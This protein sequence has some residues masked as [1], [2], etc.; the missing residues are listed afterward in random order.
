MKK[1]KKLLIAIVIIFMVLLNN[2]AFA[3]SIN[4]AIGKTEYSQEFLDWL[5]LDDETKKNSIMPR[6]YN[7]YTTKQSYTNP[8]KRARL[9]RSTLETQYNLKNYIKDNMKIKNQG[10]MGSCWTFSAL[11]AL[12]TN[13][14]MQDLNNSR[15]TKIYDFSERHMDFSTA[16]EFLNGQI[17]EKGFNRT[18][19]SG[20]HNS[21]ALAYLTNG[22]GAIPESEMPY[23]DD[24]SL[25]DISEIQN[26]TVSSQLYDTIDFATPSIETKEDLVTAM[27]NHIRTYGGISCT[28]HE[29]DILE[30]KCL[31]SK[32]GAIY[33]NDYNT[34]IAN[35]AVLIVGWDDN[36]PIEN[37][38]T[39][40][41]NKGAWIIRDTHGTNEDNSMT[42]DELKNL[43]FETF[44]DD[45]IEEGIN[46][47]D[48]ITDEK[49]EEIIKKNGFEKLEDG[50]VFRP[51]NDDGYLYVSYEDDNIYNFLMGI[52]KANDS[53]DYENIYQYDEFSSFIPI[54]F[55][56]N[57]IYLSNTFKKQTDS[58]EY[59]TQVSVQTGETATCKVYVNPNGTGKNKEDL[60]L[61]ELKS[62]DSETVEA[63]YHTL[64]FLKPIEITGSDFV[65]VIEMQGKR[66]KEMQVPVECDVAKFLKDSEGID[67]PEGAVANFFS[68][69]TTEDGKCCFSTDEGLDSGYW[70]NLSDLYKLSRGTQPN[71]DSTIKAFTVS[72]VEDDS[73][74]NIEI[75]TPP[76]KTSYIEGENFDD[77]GMVVK[78]NYNNNTSKT[79]N[80]SDYSITNG[81]NLQIGQESVTISYEDKSVEQP[82][83]VEKNVI[84]E[85]KIK[86]PPT[87][88]EYREG[89]NF[90]RTGMVVEA[91]YKNGTT[92]IITD[93]TIEDG[94]NLK[95]DQEYVTI[96]Y[97]GISVKQNIKIN[98]SNLIEIKVTQAPDKVNYKVG[99]DFDKTGM[100]V[101]GVYEDGTTQEIIDYVVEDGTDLKKGQTSVTIKYQDKTVTQ[102]ITVDD[103]VIT[104]ISISKMPTKTKY[105]KNSESLD[106]TG[107]KLKLEYADGTSREIDLNSEQ[108][109][110]TGFDNTKVGK[111]IITVTYQNKTTTFEVEIIEEVKPVNSNFDNSKLTVNAIKYYIFTDTNIPSYIL[112][113]LEVDN[114]SKNNIND[115][116]KYYYYLSPNPSETN[117]EDWVEIKEEQSE[118]NKLKFTVN[119]K[120]LKKFSEIASEDVVY[121]YIKEVAIKGQNESVIITNPLKIDGKDTDIETY[122]DNV[123][124]DGNN[125]RDSGS[126]GER[127]DDEKMPSVL[128]KAGQD[129]SGEKAS[130]LSSNTILK[131]AIIIFA[132]GS[133]IVVIKILVFKKKD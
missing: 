130:A 79:L 124:F 17:N 100:K 9:L 43:Y 18:A 8:L 128:P 12:E 45:L 106:L 125:G 21:V 85:I 65:V 36:Y 42:I 101:Y 109:Q 80:K 103:I 68:F 104:N 69:V 91:T 92:S 48:D 126:T 71:C 74:K 52:Q 97:E 63:G 19:G 16:R 86:T 40:P 55:N 47:P 34:H 123:K 6:A 14:A 132:I 62:G 60:Q 61:V 66:D 3:V 113:N 31:N 49:V 64:E 133:L 11:G 118:N 67:L 41:K 87:K 96:S 75:I 59:I 122:L 77:T 81:T 25:I 99:E 94:E 33:C 4:D 89:E 22:M 120:D 76:E 131:C 5:K 110:V 72:K 70:A 10:T 102:E 108:V 24:S 78:A 32:T 37:F 46:S 83:T 56:A 121:L 129:L 107:G 39:K 53:V 111:N 50:R 93:Y 105:L 88:I 54:T 90:D 51:H 28:I 44:K 57:D 116:Y 82:I 95:A 98:S 73:L 38:E 119:S 114:I 7:I 1:S 20:G 58:S 23:I 26:K 115:N 29:Q 13:L 15:P 112:L 35:H 84:T 27:K 117:I 2:N 127:F 30:Q